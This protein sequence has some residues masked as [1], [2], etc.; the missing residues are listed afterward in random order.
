MA[1]KLLRS[2]LCCYV[3]ISC[4]HLAF[5]KN[6]ATSQKHPAEANNNVLKPS[7]TLDSSENKNPDNF[8]Q[9]TTTDKAIFQQAEKLLRAKKY[10]EYYSLKAK[11]KQTVLLPYLQYQEIKNDPDIF[12]QQT[13]QN[14]LK[15]NKGSYWAYLLK[16][17]LASYYASK[18]NWALFIE[19]YDDNLDQTG[20]CYHSEARYALSSDN[21]DK[22]KALQEYSELWLHK[23]HLPRA[24]Q[25]FEATW[26]EAFDPSNDLIKKK[27]YLLALAGNYEA[28]L[29]WINK[30]KDK[31]LIDFYTLWQKSVE[32]PKKYL[33]DWVAEFSTNPKFHQA[34]IAVIDKLS[35]DNTEDTAELWQQFKQ[36]KLLSTK[37]INLVNA[38]IAIDFARAHD[39]AALDWLKKVE[40]RH[41]SKLLWAWRLRTAIYWWRPHDYLLWYQQAPQ[42]LQSKTTWRY[43]LAKSYQSLKQ[44]DK[45]RPIFEEIAK[46]TNYYGFLSADILQKPYALDFQNE[47]STEKLHSTLVN[48]LGVSEAMALY[49]LGQYE[50]SFQLWRWTL[51]KEHFS[52]DEI[53]TLAEIT[54]HEKMYQLS[55]YAYERIGALSNIKSRFPLAFFNDV[56]K[57]AKKFDLKPELILAMMHQESKFRIG[58]ESFAGALGLMQLMPRTAEFLAQKYH[59]DFEGQGDLLVPYNNIRL[60]AANLDFMDKLFTNHQILGIA[61]Y[62]AGQGNVAK[63][64]PKSAID[65]D[66][67]IEIIPFRETRRYIRHIL[68]YMVIYS[69]EV[70]NKSDFR[71]QQIMRPVAVKDKK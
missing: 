48:N 12:E 60:G 16:K 22:E 28:A 43:W 34:F 40:H 54:N 69:R 46:E 42:S 44:M 7:H 4:N 55:V 10:S 65:A 52:R 67:W 14:Y 21:L 1:T 3:I 45:A 18:Q 26:L 8:T 66:Q 64:L 11:L 63:W 50:I 47:S 30:T 35:K 24:C 59:F 5:S 39:K 17:D 62:N 38:E 71:L 56:K 27:S 36:K 32:N 49:Q 25:D 9:I 23:A 70:F 19:Y 37:T 68:A 6:I 31:Q 15:E 53:L 58:A 20:Q 13:I 51:K 2:V 41:G 29:H 57:V 33:D 61:A